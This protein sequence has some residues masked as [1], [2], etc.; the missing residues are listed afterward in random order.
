M[1]K[2]ENKDQVHELEKIRMQKMKALLQAQKRKQQ[3]EESQTN[4]Q[5]KIDYVLR[6]VLSLDAH[7]YLN[8]LKQKEPHVYRYIFNELVSADVIQNID[9]LLSIIQ[10]RGGIPKRIPIDVIMYLE[11]Q[12]KGIKSSIK[13]KRGDEIQDLGS[14]LTKKK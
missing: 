4:F 2:N 1:E 3:F 10:H 14:F 8:N 9:Q 13:V 12:V 6:A 11:R 5:D 7:S